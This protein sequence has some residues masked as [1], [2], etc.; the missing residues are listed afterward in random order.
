[1]L[2]S[3]VGAD[4]LAA[5]AE[6]GKHTPRK[7]QAAS[8]SRASSRKK[9][10]AA[11]PRRAATKRE[12][13]KR[14]KT[15]AAAAR[16]RAVISRR[17]QRLNR[18]FVVSSDLKPMARQLIQNR[19]RAAY[20]GVQA[21]ARKHAQDDAGA[22]ANLVLGYA[23]ILDHDY[24]KAVDPLKRAQG[25]A[26]ELGDYVAYL[27]ASA[28]GGSGQSK[29]VV[30][31]LAEFPSKYPD[32]IFLRDA[33]EIYAN[34]L[35]AQDRAGE[36]AAVLEK[37][38]QPLRADIELAL[39]RAYARLGDTVRAGEALRRVYYTMPLAPEASDAKA[40]LE[41]LP[42]PAPAAFAERKQRA[43][44][45]AQGRRHTEAV[46]EYRSLIADAVPAE[47]YG[48]QVAL[49]VALHRAGNNGEARQLLESLPETGDDANAQRLLALAEIAR[50][51]DDDGRFNELISRMR[52]TA[53]TNPAF[54]DALLLGGNMY[55]LRRDY[56][57]A[58]DFYRELQQRFPA[59]KRASYAHWK[60][61][62]LTLRQGRKEEA[63]R[64]FE[65]Q[66]AW[67]P[68][69][70]EVPAALYW[71]ARLAEDD[72]DLVK[73]RSW[74]KKLAERFPHYYYAD[75]ARQRLR[76][77]SAT[78][79]PPPDPILERIPAVAVPSS[80]A[81]AALPAD[82]VRLQKSML[83]RNGGLTEFA[84]RELRAAAEH[85]GASWANREIARIYQ[86]DGQYHR[87]LQ[88]LKRAVPTYYALEINALPRPYWEGLFPRPFWT[89]LKR[90]SATNRLDPFLVASLIRQESEFNPGA[91]SR[92]DALGL[93]QLL[94]VTGRKVAR[95]L[96]IRRF[97]TSQLLSPAT[98]I[99]LGT[100]YFQQLVAHFDGRLEYALAAYNA[101]PDRVQ[102]WL[103]DGHFR[104]PQEFVESIPFT[105]TREYVQ[106]ILR[107]ASM[108]R[109]IYADAAATSSTAS[110]SHDHDSQGKG[111][112][113][114]SL[115]C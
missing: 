51:A 21:Y 92:A 61:A 104:D 96:R 65:A 100:R 62:W 59:S 105:E 9:P 11:A 13:A 47:R 89:D 20:A 30:D 52:E 79:D 81:S 69:A 107:N 8:A 45:L 1:L 63:K 36:A 18:A 99:Q 41:R 10:K 58:I 101:G 54:A 37:Y 14:E 32:S 35:M 110:Q 85:G 93:M 19:T 16:R 3:A 68:D 83:L 112:C 27:L 46:A 67:Y 72:N 97:S 66:V 56:D 22:L 115:G 106:A 43:D 17:A 5:S 26:G 77:L 114:S 82:D 44:L 48:L 33:M 111:A 113:S 78:G 75:L 2:L 4:L 38:R 80:L 57:R 87:A 25:H 28:Y 109:R 70:A 74:Y 86:E 84:I 95:D 40:A 15:R 50:A 29:D 12:V 64:D 34:A 103:A 71:R 55:L 108:Y 42:S 7:S 6:S 39:G 90:F 91:V 98:N 73:A 60:A 88:T 49:G 24:A 94:P 102:S 23:H 53:S 76:T 31:T